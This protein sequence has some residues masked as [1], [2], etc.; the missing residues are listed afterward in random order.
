MMLT[1]AAEIGV[2]MMTEDG[3]KDGLLLRFFRTRKSHNEYYQLANYPL[4]SSFPPMQTCSHVP[5]Q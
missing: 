1:F 3:S 5:W 2:D 4:L